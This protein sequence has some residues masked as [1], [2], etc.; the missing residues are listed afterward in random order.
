MLNSVTLLGHLG[1]HPETKVL[2]SGNQVTRIS[3]ATSHSYK[4]RDGD[5][6]EET[7]WHNVIFW[8]G[9]AEIAQRYLRKGH[10]CCVV[11]RI[12]YRTVES[13]SGTRYY[14]D[15]VANE[16]KLLERRERNDFP[17]EEEEWV[18]TTKPAGVAETTQR[19]EVAHH[20]AP[21]DDLPF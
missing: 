2:P 10:K 3:L 7:A 17:E 14:T 16:L 6:Q 5:R 11:G 13:E 9:L 8:G 12:K 20:P 4:T 21:D 18:A 1:Q 19:A 15:I